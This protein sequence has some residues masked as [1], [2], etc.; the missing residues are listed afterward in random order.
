MPTKLFTDSVKYIKEHLGII[1]MNN[2]SWVST[3][4]NQHASNIID[5]A[6]ELTNMAQNS[7][8]TM[9]EEKGGGNTVCKRKLVHRSVL[10]FLWLFWRTDWQC[11]WWFLIYINSRTAKREKDTCEAT[12]CCQYYNQTNAQDRWGLFPC[13]HRSSLQWAWTHL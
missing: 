12:N 9:S 2:H 3:E 4:G 1:I 11:S 6:T 5:A 8:Q 13:C 10:S 7:E